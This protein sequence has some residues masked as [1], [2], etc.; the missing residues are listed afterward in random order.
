M[1]KRNLFLTAI[2]LGTG[3]ALLFSQ[4]NIAQV[5]NF[6]QQSIGA[7]TVQNPSQVPG[8]WIAMFSALIVGISMI[9]TPCL[10]PVILSFVPAAR[11]S[12]SKRQVFSNLFFY[13]LGLIS[14]SALIGLLVGFLGGQI[15]SLL[16]NFTGVAKPLAIA[17]FSGMG[18]LFLVWGLRAFHLID[19]PSTG[20][21]YKLTNY[22]ESGSKGEKGQSLFYGVAVGTA[23]GV[24][25]P[26]PT[27]HALLLWAAIVGDPLFGLVLLTTLGIGRVIP[28]WIAML[29]PQRQIDVLI[30][31]VKKNPKRMHTYNG[32]VITV[33]G[34]FLL[35]FW[36]GVSYLGLI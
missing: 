34:S 5:Q 20:L 2:L 1:K 35:I 12:E 19:L 4:F 14:V 31:K 18:V 21:Y 24:S 17:V 36:I 27:Y 33:L 11:E 32:F 16:Q 22:I 25:C 7:T 26:I 29:L 13:S 6:L 8:F 10:I 9:A 30:E 3:L 28:L 23:L 15:M